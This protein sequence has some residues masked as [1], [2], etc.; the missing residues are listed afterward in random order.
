MRANFHTHTTFCDGK[1]TAEQMVRTAIEKG[2]IALGF[3]GHSYTDFDPHVGMPPA[4][5]AEYRAEIRR[6]KEA[7]SGNIALF[8]GVEQDYYS[9]KAPSEYDY[10]IASVHYIR[11][12]GE[13]LFVDWSEQR[14]REI[15]RD[16]YAGDPYAYAEDYYRL[17]GGVLD[18][19]G[20][21]IVGHFDLI[22]KFDED[23][24]MFDEAHPRYRSAVLDALDRLCAARPVFE[25]NTG[26]MARGYRSTPYPSVWIL[27]EIHSRGCPVMIS[28]DCHHCAQL[29]YGY[30]MA[31]KLAKTA[32]FECQVRW[33][34]GG[35]VDMEL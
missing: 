33:N 2:F 6:L 10:A 15:V 12:D 29:D 11:K 34:D 26:A 28:S 17:V 31:V 30:D 24:A 18:A 14:T 1:S 4:T 22:R 20:G 25:I 8:C 21:S 16:H 23:G 32:G 19:T 9:G 3:S 27:R 5:A 7:Y 35:F 13:Y